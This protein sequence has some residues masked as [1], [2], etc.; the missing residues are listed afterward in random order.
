MHLCGVPSDPGSL[1]TVPL[2]PSLNLHPCSLPSSGR[3]YRLCPCLWRLQVSHLGRAYQQL[4]VL[5]RGSGHRGLLVYLA[6]HG[7]YHEL[8]AVHA[9]EG[10]CAAWAQGTQQSH[11]VLA[12]P[13]ADHGVHQPVLHSVQGELPGGTG[14]GGCRWLLLSGRLHEPHGSHHQLGQAQILCLLLG[15][16]VYNWC[17]LR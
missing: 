17:R 8:P 11:L 14:L 10:G 6:A 15:G 7:W 3:C 12:H 13:P 9:A 16:S 5:H 1:L 2:P 4:P